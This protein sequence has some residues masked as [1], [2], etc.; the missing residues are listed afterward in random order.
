MTI[1][2]FTLTLAEDHLDIRVDE[3]SAQPI[4]PIVRQVAPAQFK[5][6]TP[7]DDVVRVQWTADERALAKELPTQL[8]AALSAETHEREVKENGHV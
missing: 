1:P 5:V 6:F 7:L 8:A 3:G 2:T 4:K